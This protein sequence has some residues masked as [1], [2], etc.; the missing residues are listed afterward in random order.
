MKYLN[1]LKNKGYRTL[2]EAEKD[3]RSTEQSKNTHQHTITLQ[4]VSTHPFRK[5]VLKGTCKERIWADNRRN[6]VADS[7]SLPNNTAF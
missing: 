2:A 4:K 3:Q 1:E 5:C 7:I 6:Y